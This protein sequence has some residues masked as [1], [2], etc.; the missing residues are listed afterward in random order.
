MATEYQFLGE[1]NAI[2]YNAFGF[3][4]LQK[5]V[6]VPDL[7]ANPGKLALA[8]APTVPLTSFTSFDGTASD[9]LNVFHV[10]AGFMAITGGMRIATAGTASVTGELGIG[11]NTA[12]LMAT[13]TDFDQAAETVIS[14]I[15]GDAWSGE[16]VNGNVFA[17]ADT[18]DILFAGA[19]D[20][21][22]VYD[23]FVV[24]CK[25]Y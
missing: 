2:P 10:P 18:I 17:A 7:I 25:V 9:I 8:S 21:L 1:T 15:T 23:F 4:V 5:R 3:A 19:A 16:A 11:G 13:S 12:A 6:D 22:G 14:T 24:G 20:I